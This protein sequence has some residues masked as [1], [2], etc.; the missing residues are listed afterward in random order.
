MKQIYLLL[1]CLGFSSFAIAME[2]SLEKEYHR[3]YPANSSTSLEIENKYG[4]VEFIAWDKD[5]VN[6][7]VEVTVIT[8]DFSESMELRD[9]ILIN[10][11]NA[12]SFIVAETTW[13]EEL[14]FFKK[15]LLGIG[16]TFSG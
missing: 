11:Q 10:F 15:K 6:I 2:H 7:D 14:S 9:A 8:D 12:G 13:S 4:D 16:Q 3:S 1:I 5:S